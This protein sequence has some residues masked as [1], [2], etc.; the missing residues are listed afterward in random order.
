[1]A[2]KKAGLPPNN[3]FQ[4]ATASNPSLNTMIGMTAGKGKFFASMMRLFL[5]FKNVFR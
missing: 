3:S 4:A 2:T 1:M 5:T